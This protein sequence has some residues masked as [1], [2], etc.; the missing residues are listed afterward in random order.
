MYNHTFSA[1][2]IFLQR[3]SDEVTFDPDPIFK[4]NL[5]PDM[6]LEKTL[7]T[8]LTMILAFEASL[9]FLTLT[10]TFLTFG[11]SLCSLAICR[12]SLA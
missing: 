9:G 4:N 8:S 11:I 6:I 12:I 10:R 5:D 7:I 1:D 2:I 3:P